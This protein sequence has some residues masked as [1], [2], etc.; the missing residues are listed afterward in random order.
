MLTYIFLFVKLGPSSLVF[1]Y[2]RRDA[3]VERLRLWRSE[4]PCL[5]RSGIPTFG[6]VICHL[7]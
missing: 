1:H 6:L 5:V 2:R 3:G 7:W 4:I